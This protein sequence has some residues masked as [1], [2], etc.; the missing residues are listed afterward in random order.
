MIKVE[1][2]CDNN[3]LGMKYIKKHSFYKEIYCER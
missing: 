1:L 2:K 3:T